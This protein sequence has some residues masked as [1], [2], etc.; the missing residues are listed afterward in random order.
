[1]TEDFQETTIPYP[2]II[3][4]FVDGGWDGYLLSEYEGAHKDEPGFVSE[5]LKRQHIMMKRIL[6]Y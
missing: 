3:K 5:Q 4:E 1:M 2:E 6:G